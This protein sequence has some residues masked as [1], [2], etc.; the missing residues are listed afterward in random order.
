MLGEFAPEDQQEDIDDI[1][2]KLEGTAEIK[3]SKWYDDYADLSD[4]AYV[5]AK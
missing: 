2:V 1:T 4:Y 3:Q 5:Y